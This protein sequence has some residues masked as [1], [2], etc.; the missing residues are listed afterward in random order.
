MRSRMVII[1]IDD[2]CRLFADYA[3]LTG[4]P[5]DAVCETLLAHPPSRKMR[6]RVSSQEWDRDQAPEQIRFDLTR[7]FLP[8]LSN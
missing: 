3:H 8:G 2:I 4:F 1:G 5:E 7:T 6:L